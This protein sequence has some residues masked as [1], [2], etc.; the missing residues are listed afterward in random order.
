MLGFLSLMVVGIVNFMFTKTADADSI[1]QQAGFYEDS[2]GLQR[3]RLRLDGAFDLRANGG[4]PATS[5]SLVGALASSIRRSV[6]S[7]TLSLGI[8]RD[9]YRDSA[10]QR[11]DKM[12]AYYE[13]G[14]RVRDGWN[15][16]WNSTFSKLTDMRLLTS[17]QNDGVVR[18][19]NFAAGV[20]RWI[21]HE[22]IQLNL[23]FSRSL[24][25]RPELTIVDADTESISPPPLL[26]STGT[27]LSVKHLALP[28]TV[29]NY[30]ATLIVTNE[31][32][33]RQDYQF[34][35]KHYLKS[36]KAALHGDVVRSINRGKLE[37]TTID[38]QLDAWIFEVAYLQTLMDGAFS[39]LAW[40]QYRE[41]E[42]TRDSYQ[43]ELVRGTDLWSLSLLADLKKLAGL[44][45]VNLELSHSR[46]RT[47][48]IVAG[49]V[50]KR[51]TAAT[52]EIGAAAKF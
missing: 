36:Q 34:G 47:N 52:Y 3:Q 50:A 27:T 45:P 1:R 6:S 13:G 22:S 24:V 18:A 17:A 16:G 12:T 28:T 21:W 39:R 48:P 43:D 10:I 37:N 40:R 51:T 32:P 19:R 7:S 15:L 30:S 25:D 33:L 2:N 38:G 8:E 23:D 11:D 31:R 4:G 46:Y 26:T 41:D 29:T 9:I 14:R 5:D 42:V 44:A 35:V 49:T 20:S